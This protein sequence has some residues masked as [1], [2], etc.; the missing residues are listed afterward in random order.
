MASDSR[1][2][3]RNGS[4]FGENTKA[5]HGRVHRQADIEKI[6][7]TDGGCFPM[8]TSSKQNSF[9]R[10][11]MAGS[12]LFATIAIFPGHAHARGASRLLDISISGSFQKNIQKYVTSTKRSVGVEIGLPLTDVVDLSFGHTQILDLD[13]YNEAYREAK[14]AQGVTLPEG[15]IEQKTQIVDSSANASF[16]HSFG[17]VKPTLF[18][19]ALWRRSCLEDTFQD[20]GCT[21]QSVTWNAGIAISAIITMK[22]RFRL[23]YRISPSIHQD[24]PRKNLDELVSV[25]LSW[26]L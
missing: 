19:G 22:T 18:G 8:Q 15:A 7:C 24:D 2:N 14:A 11:T 6:I 25:G 12:I 21:D 5:A 4:H 20:Y 23:S 3:K 13:V 10:T 16:G 1:H 9:A 26:S 17:Y